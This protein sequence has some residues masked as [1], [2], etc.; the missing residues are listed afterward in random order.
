MKENEIML[1]F[2]LLIFWIGS[3]IIASYDIEPISLETFILLWVICVIWRIWVHLK[4]K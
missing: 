4:E 3:I 2:L 1:R